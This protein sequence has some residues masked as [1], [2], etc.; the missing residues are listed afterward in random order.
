MDIGCDII[1][2]GTVHKGTYH[3]RTVAIK[4]VR[5]TKVSQSAIKEFRGELV[6]MAPLRHPNLV[7]LLGACWEEGPDKLCLVLEFCAKGSLRELLRCRDASLVWSAPY[8][9]CAP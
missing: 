2:F 6:V 4:T 9:G 8:G 1:S 7:K 3:D 5:A